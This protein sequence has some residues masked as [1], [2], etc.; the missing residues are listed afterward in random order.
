VAGT[1]SFTAVDDGRRIEVRRDA[2]VPDEFWRRVRAEWGQ[3][4]SE[5]NAA[6]LVPTELFAARHSWLPEVGRRYGVSVQIDPPVRTL[7][8]RA[9]EE[10]QRLVEIRSDPPDIDP[11]RLREELHGGRF[12]R[13]LLPFQERDASKLLAIENGA[14]FSVPGAGKTSVELAVYEA[15]RLAGRVEQLLVIAPLSSLDTWMEEADLS[16]RPAPV[17]DR[18]V[19]SEI[20]G[21]IELLLVNYQRLMGSYQAVASW[22]LRRPTLVVLDE[23]HRM[24]RGRDG[25]WGRACLDLAFLAARRDI[26]T[27][28]PAP[29]HPSDLVALFDFLWPGQ[30]MRILPEEAMVP[31]PESAQVG[32]VT[33]RIAPL[34]ARTTKVELNLRPPTK[35]VIKVPLVGIHRQIYESLRQ[36]FSVLTRTQR[37]R[38]ELSSW[39]STVMYL[40][41]AAT[42]PA[43]LPAG[44]SNG[45]PIEF[46]HPPL[47]IPPDSSLHDLVADYAQYEVPAKFVQLAAL[48]DRLRGEDL[49]VLVWSNFVR[50]L[51]ILEKMLAFHEPALVH[52]GIPSEVT[53]P[54]SPRVREHELIR[55]REDPNCGVLLA[56]PAAMGEGV[57]LH[58]ECHHAVYLERTFNAGQ[59]L[60]SVDR[61]HRLGMKAGV[62][63]TIHFLVTEETV[64]ETVAD[65]IEIKAQN[66]GLMLDDSAIATMA[67][68]D[69]EDIG[70]PLDVGGDSDI[71][72]L[73]EHLRGDA[74]R[75]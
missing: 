74:D 15:E 50:N 33:E 66:L 75:G 52:G 39:S 22:A 62:E 5:P 1:T 46:R 61:I 58:H 31:Q 56:N 67:L 11:E 24:K 55:F 42:N 43:L 32:R 21:D 64:D 34:F 41:E 59:Y 7:L 20:P 40:L 16:L 17:I 45:D 54:N 2:E 63:T 23:A 65:R 8:A 70:Q 36:R 14:N 18:F 10:R 6:V 37:E 25:E 28:T 26:L 3:L 51:E 38:L 68:P 49:K 73:F 53:Q 57:S 30:A 4:G 48:V 27:G 35:Q 12:I 9:R 29:Q 72:A 69:D 47:P 19:G 71:E 60:Q 13:D 44:S